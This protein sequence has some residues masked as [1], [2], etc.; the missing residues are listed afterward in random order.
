MSIEWAEKAKGEA[1]IDAI[2][3]KVA[4]LTGYDKAAANLIRELSDE[5]KDKGFTVDIVAGASLQDLT[6]EVEGIGEVVQSFTSLGA[7]D[8]VLSSWNA[9]QAA[10]T[11]LYGL[12]ALTFVGFTFVNLLADR[13]KDEQL[14]ARLGWSQKLISRIRYKEWAWMLGIPI[15]SPD[16]FYFGWTVGRSMDTFYLFARY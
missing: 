12:V 16:R 14:L 2:R 13:Q 4:G 10:L 9:L 8:T 5:W 15:V 1:P 3:V 7:A 6:V 11:V